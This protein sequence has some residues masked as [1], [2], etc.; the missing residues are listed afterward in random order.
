MSR[1][2]RRIVKSAEGC[3]PRSGGAGGTL[4]GKSVVK[5]SGSAFEDPEPRFDE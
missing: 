3:K 2:E 1:L 4:I 5:P